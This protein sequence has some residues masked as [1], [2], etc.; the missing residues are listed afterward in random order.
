MKDKVAWTVLLV[1]SVILVVGGF[2]GAIGKLLAC[3]LVPAQIV[4]DSQF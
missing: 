1:L 4:D 3:I 2:Q